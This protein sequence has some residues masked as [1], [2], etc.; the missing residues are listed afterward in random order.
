MAQSNVYSLNIVG[1]ATVTV[2]PNYSLLANPLSGG[3]TNGANEIMPVIDG[4]LILTWTGSK[5]SQ[6]GYDSGFGGWV[7]ADGVTPSH[8]PVLNPG[9]GFFFFNPGAATNITFVGTVVPNP[10]GSQ[11]A[12]QLPLPSNYSLI[13]SPLPA[14]VAQITNPPVSLPVIDGMLILSWNGSK[15]VQTGFDSGF[16]G[17]VAADGVT[18]SVAP[19]YSIGQGFFFFNPGAATTWTQSLP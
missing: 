11:N 15:Y 13:G 17:W 16:G 1:Y 6:T 4:E 14:T 12:N 8:P 18:P 19:P 3:A 5:F 2:P 7:G 9:T 10:G